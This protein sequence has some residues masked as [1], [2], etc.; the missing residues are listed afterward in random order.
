[1][2]PGDHVQGGRGEVY[3]NGFGSKRCHPWG[4]QVDESIFPFTNRFFFG[5]PVFLT[6]RQ[7]VFFF[8]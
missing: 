2:L 7:N 5:Y 3:S 1:M 4:P 6:H 8:F